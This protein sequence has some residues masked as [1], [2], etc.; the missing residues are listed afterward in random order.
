[1][2]FLVKEDILKVLYFNLIDNKIEVKKLQTRCGRTW[3]IFLFI[4]KSLWRVISQ[5]TP[6]EAAFETKLRINGRSNERLMSMISDSWCLNMLT[7]TKAR[8]REAQ[9]QSGEGKEGW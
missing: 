7:L 1:M 4:L 3:I 6:L 9:F 8:K 5:I 2:W